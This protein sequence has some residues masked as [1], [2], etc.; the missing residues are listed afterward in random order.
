MNPNNLACV[1]CRKRVAVVRG[2]CFPCRERQRKDIKAGTTTE[3]ELVASGKLI[4][5]KKAALTLWTKPCE[6]AGRTSR[7]WQ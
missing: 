5:S 6:I 7:G 3:A 1:D 2:V 4:P